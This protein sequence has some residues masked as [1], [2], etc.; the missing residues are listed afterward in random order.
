MAVVT[1]VRRLANPRRVS[2]VG[3]V[4]SRAAKRRGM[5]KNPH[6]KLS[7]KQI[8]YFGTSRQKAALR[9]R[10]RRAKVKV[11]PKRKRVIT[12]AG[13]VKK[14]TARSKSRARRR[15][16]PAP[17]IVTLGAAN[18]RKRRFSTMAR[19]R[20]SSK[21]NPSRKRTRLVV[22]APHR[23]R[24]RRYSMNPRRRTRRMRANP[25]RRRI[26]RR[27]PFAIQ[28]SGGQMMKAVGAGIV[29]VAAAKLIPT[30]LPANILGGGGALTKI[31]LA[32]A[33]AFVASWAAK[34][35]GAGDT[36]ASSVLFGGL[37]YT[38]SLAINAALPASISAKLSLGELMPGSFPVPQNPIIQRQ[39][40]AAAPVAGQ[41]NQVRVP[42]NGIGRA[43][44]S[45]Y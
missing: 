23:K 24:T 17:I 27:N 20:K 31:A 9:S 5:S 6:R 8:K 28:A 26:T 7:A 33:S 10:N 14:S 29:G 32:G 4:K 15:S 19:K 1:K 37:M 35:A 39:L 12:R 34:K 45:A 13:A 38:G 36:V 40:A 16:N 43:F 30:F 2:R 22:A 18:P 21:R 11:N 3:R 41:P 42:M 25:R 44:G